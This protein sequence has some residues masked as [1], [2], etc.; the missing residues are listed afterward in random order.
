MAAGSDA[1][2]PPR[3]GVLELTS[4]NARLQRRPSSLRDTPRDSLLPLLTKNCETGVGGGGVGEKEGQRGGIQRTN[5]GAARESSPRARRLSIATHCNTPPYT[6][7]H[8]E[9]SARMNSGFSRV[10]SSSS[11]TSGFPG[12]SRVASWNSSFGL[13]SVPSASSK[14]VRAMSLVC[15][16]VR[17]SAGG[18]VRWRVCVRTPFF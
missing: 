16:A 5:S 13:R 11:T 17:V 10:S 12:F 3:E 8:T 4:A 2:A 18:V 9:D 6:A 7:T 1:L 14:I 15:A